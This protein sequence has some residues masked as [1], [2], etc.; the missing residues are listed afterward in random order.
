MKNRGPLIERSARST[1][2]KSIVRTI[3][4]NSF[5]ID[6]P[7]SELFYQEMEFWTS[8]HARPAGHHHRHP[9][10]VTQTT[11]VADFAPD[12]VIHTGQIEN[13]EGCLLYFDFQLR[14]GLAIRLRDE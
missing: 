4:S 3:G 5:R 11:N 14:E 1:A 12:V 13:Y 9:V 7:C 10:S 2:S 8:I 6:E